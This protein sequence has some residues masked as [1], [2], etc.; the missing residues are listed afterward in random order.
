VQAEHQ[1]HAFADDG[2]IVDAQDPNAA[3]GRDEAVYRGKPSYGAAP[4]KILYPGRN[5]DR[6]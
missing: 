3:R 1:C 2:M 5:S 4:S 6:S